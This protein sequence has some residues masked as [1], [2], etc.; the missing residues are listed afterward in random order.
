MDVDLPGPADL[1]SGLACA[2]A[3]KHAHDARTR[4][5]IADLAVLAALGDVVVLDAARWHVRP[6][7]GPLV[8]TS[9]RR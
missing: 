9:R 4:R 5:K 7:M 6:R 3:P 8:T 1:A 2:R